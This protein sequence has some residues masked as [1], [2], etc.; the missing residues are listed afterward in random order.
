V[1]GELWDLERPLEQSA[2]L[3]LLDFDHPE[4]MLATRSPPLLTT[5]SNQARRCFGTRP[6]TYWERPPKDIM[7]V[8]YVLVHQRTTVFSMKWRSR[9][10]DNP[11]FILLAFN[12]YRATPAEW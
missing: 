4:G 1:D 11:P 12:P 6:H 7:D 3:E 5:L 10:G 9:T 2:K 8:I